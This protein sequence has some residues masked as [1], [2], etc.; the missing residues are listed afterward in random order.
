MI[1]PNPIK[2]NAIPVTEELVI[3]LTSL[4]GQ[5]LMRNS[6]RPLI[7]SE[8]SRDTAH[9]VTFI[10]DD[11]IFEECEAILV[12]G[13]DGTIL[14]IAGQASLHNKPVLGVNCGTIGFMSE[15]EPHE[16]FLVERLIDGQYSTDSRIMLDVTITDADGH[17]TYA[18]TVLNEA[19]V[20]KGFANKVIEL[21]VFVDGHETFGFGGD[22]VIVC[23]PTGS[24]AYSLAAGGPILAPSSACIAVTPI[25]PHSL[26]V[27]SFVVSA[28]SEITIAPHYRNH[29]IYLSADG[30]DPCELKPGDQ[31]QIRKSMRCFEL[32]RIKGKGF[33]ENIGEKL[34]NVR[35]GR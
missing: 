6:M 31:V 3:R 16:L 8:L 34:T 15:I 4:G 14:K 29:H 10:D 11:R 19:V 26:T 2:P 1:H 22:G 23:T 9:L 28:N 35:V 7:Q 24:T 20:T 21:T 30:F 33:Y 17:I 27:K 25:C 5:V 32:L 12:V 18:D 13:G